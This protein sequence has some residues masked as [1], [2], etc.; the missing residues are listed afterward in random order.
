MSV[1]VKPIITEKA[2]NQSELINCYSFYVDRD[3]NKIQV[4]Q[5]IELQYGVSVVKVNTLIENPTRTTKFTKDGM[6]NGKSNV[7]KKAFVY[8]KEGE[9]ID[10]YNNI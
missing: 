9:E 5:A 7:L 3:A 2:T 1:I 6:I 10:F 8:L 4:K